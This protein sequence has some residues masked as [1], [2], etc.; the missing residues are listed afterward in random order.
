VTYAVFGDTGPKTIVGEASYA[1]AQALGI[2]PDPKTGGVDSGVTY[3]VFTGTKVA[4]PNSNESIDSAG[5]A[6]AEKFL[7]SN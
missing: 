6:A 4:N 3:I 2:D 1:A 5:R 7:A